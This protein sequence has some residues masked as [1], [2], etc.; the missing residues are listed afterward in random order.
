MKYG[1]AFAT[2]CPA[3]VGYSIGDDSTPE[4]LLASVTNWPV[5]VSLPTA[6][7][8]YAQQGLLEKTAI[9]NQARELREKTFLRLNGIQ[10][11]L[12]WNKARGTLTAAVVDPQVE[13]IMTAKAGLKDI[14]T[15]AT[16]V[17][18]T[19]GA[20]TTAALK[21]RYAQLVAAL[22]AASPYACTAFNGLDV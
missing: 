7:A 18:A 21:V 1:T 5:E 17:A 22:Y 20:E 16:I 13:G 15:Y 9:L 4:L 19:T 11:E 14:T 3:A 12:E 10:Q 8:I 2:L 6:A